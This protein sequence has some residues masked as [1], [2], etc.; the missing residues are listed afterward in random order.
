MGLHPGENY[1]VVLINEFPYVD[2]LNSIVCCDKFTEA[3]MNVVCHQLNF[4]YGLTLSCSYF[5]HFQYFGYNAFG[6]DLQCNGSEL[7]L[8]ECSNAFFNWQCNDG[9]ASVVCSN[10]PPSLSMFF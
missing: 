5:G 2:S 6:K 1:G 7:N 9:L 4:D 10:L 3:E 8:H